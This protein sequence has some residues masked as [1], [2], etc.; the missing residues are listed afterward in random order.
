V[1]F[2]RTLLGHTG[3]VGETLLEQARFDGQFSRGNIAE[4]KDTHSELLICSAAPAQKWWANANATEDLANIQSLVSTLESMQAVK[5]V[6]I[7][8][9]DVFDNPLEIDEDS[10][11]VTSVQN[12]YGKNRRYLENEFTRIFKEALVVRLPGLVGPRLRKNALFDLKN[13]NQV[14][15]LNGASVFQFYPMEK[16]WEDLTLAIDNKLELLHLTS[17]PTSL[18]YI[19]KSIFGIE[20]ENLPDPVIYNLQTKYATLWGKQSRFQYTADQCLAAIKDYSKS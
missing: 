10:T 18:G 16:L 15:M 8:T 20:L 14:S 5:A 1:N 9:V 19:A 12:A 4:S 7:S 6:L 13:D 2:E 11:Q 17:E 3:F